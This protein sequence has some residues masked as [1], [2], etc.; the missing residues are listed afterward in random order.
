MTDQ[1]LWIL[2]LSAGVVT[3]LW[4]RRYGKPS[5]IADFLVVMAWWY[6][7]LCLGMIGLVKA[8]RK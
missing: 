8:I 3:M 7:L 5:I 4:S 2:Y 6:F 1:I